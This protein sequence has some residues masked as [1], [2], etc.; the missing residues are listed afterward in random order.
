M[1]SKLSW[2]PT[3]RPPSGWTRTSNLGIFAVDVTPTVTVGAAVTV[4]AVV[5]EIGVCVGSAGV[6]TW[7][8]NTVKSISLKMKAFRRMRL[9]YLFPSDIP[10]TISLAHHLG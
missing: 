9:L 1:I 5:E 6:A 7:Q 8:H 3:N 2:S 10:G 4:G